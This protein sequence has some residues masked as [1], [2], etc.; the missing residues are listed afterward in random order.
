LRGITGETGQV[1]NKI[2]FRGVS[3]E[4]LVL[5]LGDCFWYC[6][7][8]SHLAGKKFHEVCRKPIMNV[9]NL[10]DNLKMLAV[11]VCNLQEVSKKIDRDCLT[12]A[13]MK[14]I[15][16]LIADITSYLRFICNYYNL[17]LRQVLDRNIHKLKMR[18]QNNKLHGDGDF[19]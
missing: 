16:D 19:R 8:S 13:K 5:Q 11:A 4:D 12:D 6:A 3:L 7:T 15:I 14:S 10:D 17:D 18:Q 1:L 2:W 9:F